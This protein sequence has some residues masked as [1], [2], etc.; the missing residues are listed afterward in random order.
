MEGDGGGEGEDDDGGGEIKGTRRWI[1]DGDGDRE[2][3]N[4][5]FFMPIWHAMRLGVWIYFNSWLVHI[6][7]F[8][9]Y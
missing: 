2:K 1:D 9:K 7:V 5:C 8:L 4:D 3:W 6:F